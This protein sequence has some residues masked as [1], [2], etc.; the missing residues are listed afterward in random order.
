MPSRTWKNANFGKKSFLRSPRH[1]HTWRQVYSDR[2]AKTRPL[3]ET[4]IKQTPM[5]PDEIASSLAKPRDRNR[6]SF[7]SPKDKRGILR[8]IVDGRVRGVITCSFLQ[9]LIAAKQGNRAPLRQ[10]SVVWF[11]ARTFISR[12][13]SYNSSYYCYLRAA[14]IIAINCSL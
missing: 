5:F 14:N 3:A 9:T 4:K 6:Y 10:K 7:V 12:L 2:S 13:R 1:T 8:L 11:F